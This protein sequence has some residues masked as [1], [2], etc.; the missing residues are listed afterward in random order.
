MAT[1][2][3]VAGTLIESA[4]LNDADAHVYDQATGAHTAANIAVVDT[5]GN[6]TAT[7][8]E[9]A[10]AELAAGGI[11]L[12]AGTYTPTVT[13][14]A[15]VISPTL[16]SATYSRVGDIVTVAIRV[17]LITNA[18]S[19]ESVVFCTLPVASNFS[20]TTDATGT[21]GSNVIA[22]TQFVGYVN[23][24]PAT[25]SLAIRFQCDAGISGSII[26]IAQYRII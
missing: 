23:S 11:T 2:D 19:T 20:A 8:V 9:G 4:W 5:A 21:V 22:L 6:F 3:F 13:A 12:A 17:G 24:D 25:D 1:T 14:G 26:A 18:S 7:D 10:L 16:T 15:N